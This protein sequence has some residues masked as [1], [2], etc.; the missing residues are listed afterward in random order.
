MMNFNV[1]KE[2]QGSSTVSIPVPTKINAGVS[3]PM[4]PTGYVFPIAQLVSVSF[5]PQK[6]VTRD[7]VITKEPVLSFRFVDKEKRV[8]TKSFFIIDANDPELTKKHEEN[9]QMIKHFWDETIGEENMPEDGL[10]PGAQDFSSFYEG[11]SKAFNNAVYESPASGETPK[12]LKMFSKDVVYI[13][14]T[15]YKNKSQFP[16]FP[17]VI[18]KAK[19]GGKQVPCINLDI[20]P[21]Y[22]KLEKTAA[23][24]SGAGNTGQGYVPDTAMGSDDG[25]PDID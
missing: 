17:N 18:Q 4:Y 23:P 16:K 9:V 3:D 6:E 25:F 7:N 2:T 11:V 12:M 10:A 24:S 13:K 15:L 22:D 20:N 19:V 21:T 1:T 8:A 5:D 14:Q